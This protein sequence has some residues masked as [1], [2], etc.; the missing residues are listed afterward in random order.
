MGLAAGDLG[1]HFLGSGKRLE[2]CRQGGANS[3]LCFRNMPFASL[4]RANCREAGVGAERPAGRLLQ[5]SKQELMA[6]GLETLNDGPG[7]GSR[8]Q[9]CTVHRQHSAWRRAA[10]E[11]SDCLV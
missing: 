1:L 11:A 8:P 7:G 4:W 9:P 10:A 2:S 5:W 6:T 3:D